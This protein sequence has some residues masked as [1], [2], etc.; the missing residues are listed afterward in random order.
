MYTYIDHVW[1]TTNYLVCF[2]KNKL[3]E[4]SCKLDSTDNK[5][6]FEKYWTPLNGSHTQN[7]DNVRSKNSQVL[8]VPWNTQDT[9]KIRNSSWMHSPGFWNRLYWKTLHLLDLP[10]F[11]KK[12][13][14]KAPTHLQVLYL[15][16]PVLYITT[17]RYTTHYIL[18]GIYTCRRHYVYVYIGMCI[19]I[20]V[21]MYIYT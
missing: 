1:I 21:Y 4:R 16:V 14:K 11:P 12:K 19:C 8:S 15:L 10:F 13:P 17:I 3:D 2:H 9:C 20:Y 7:R 6:S 18:K 5:Y